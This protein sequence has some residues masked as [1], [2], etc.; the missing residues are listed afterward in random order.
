M[1]PRFLVR[2]SLLVWAVSG[3]VADLVTAITCSGF[4]RFLL[5]HGVDFHRFIG[6]GVPG[7]ISSSI[8]VFLCEELSSSFFFIPLNNSSVNSKGKFHYAGYIGGLIYL[9]DLILNIIL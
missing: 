9:E 1:F 5:I 2:G 8:F 6:M 3:D 4:L 7:L